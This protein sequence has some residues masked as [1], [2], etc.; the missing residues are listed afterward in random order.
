MLPYVVEP[1]WGE[2]LN[3]DD[4]QCGREHRDH[5]DLGEDLLRS[6]RL[7]PLTIFSSDDADFV[8]ER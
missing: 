2:V 6:S 1:H 4:V 7:E 5:C 8:D 3:L